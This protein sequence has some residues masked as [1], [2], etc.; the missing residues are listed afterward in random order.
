MKATYGRVSRY[1]AMPLSFS[2]DHVGPLCRTVTDC[3]VFTQAIAGHDPDDPTTSRE[4]VGD[5]LADIEGGV[6]GLRLGVPSN[7][8]FDDVDDDVRE[9][10]EA[11]IEVF[12][13]NLALRSSK[14][15]YLGSN[16]ASPWVKC[17][18]ALRPRRIIRLGCAN[19]RRTTAR[20]RAIV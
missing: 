4:P 18:D 20:R 11:S 1:G 17:W 16:T 6:T 2:L 3:A 5:Y 15:K 12:L 8:F 10:I 13:G 9:A 7:H 14:L 19:G